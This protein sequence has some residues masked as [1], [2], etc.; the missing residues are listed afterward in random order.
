MKNFKNMIQRPL[1]THIMAEDVLI[2]NFNGFGLPTCCPS[3][4]NQNWKIDFLKV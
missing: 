4:Q 1:G 3:Q 2:Q